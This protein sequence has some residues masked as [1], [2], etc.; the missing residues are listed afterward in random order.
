M[1]EKEEEKLLE[2]KE[3]LE[4]IQLPLDEADE[5]IRQGFDRAKREKIKA[6]KKRTRVWSLVAA[7]FLFATFVTSI[8]VSPAFANAVASIPGMEKFVDLIQ[9]DKGLE[10]IFK[11]DYYQK[12]DSFQTINGLTLTID[13]AIL[14]ET[15]MNIYYTF[16][17]IDRLESLS[18][19]TVDLKHEEGIP[20]SGISYGG[21]DVDNNPKEV[22]NRVTYHFENPVQFKNLSFILDMDVT[23]QGEDISFSLPFELRENVKPGR[24]FVL[25]E[26]IEI[27]SQ[28]L[29]I[30][31]IT[32]YPLRVAVKVAFDEAN[33]KKILKFEDM[34]LEDEKGEVW[35]SIMNGVTAMGSETYFLQSNYFEQPKKLYLRINKMQ[36]LDKDEATLLVDTEKGQILDGPKDGKLQIL[37]ASKAGLHIIM[38]DSGGDQYHSYDIFSTGIDANGKEIYI[39]STGMY[40]EEEIR[41]WDMTFETTDYTN[42][43]RFDL[44]NYPNYITG[45]VKVEVK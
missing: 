16:K 4:K 2:M 19:K 1:Y 21:I 30:K 35:G 10:A 5:A 15:G 24:T 36:A 32:I 14:D 37:S 17:S 45:N 11:N 41:H 28:K 44:T 31:E 23:F 13:G 26:E 9:Y 39:S 38:P 43:L 29:T 25:N 27:E 8:R 42:P 12:V 6:R 22:A 34:R 20:A 7:A 33:T 18:I 3:Q 40:M